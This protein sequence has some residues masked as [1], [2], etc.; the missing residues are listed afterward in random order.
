VGALAY[1]LVLPSLSPHFL[2]DPSAWWIVDKAALLQ[3]GPRQMHDLRS[4]QLR[5]RHGS[6]RIRR[7]ILVGYRLSAM[8]GPK[9]MPPDGA[10]SIR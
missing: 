4:C 2:L 8:L 10:R 9:T 7:G 5:I 1:R 3:D 6:M